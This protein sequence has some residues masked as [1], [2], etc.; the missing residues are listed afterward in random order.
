VGAVLA[1]VDAK[2]HAHLTWAYEPVWAIGTGRTASPEDATEAHAIVRAAIGVAGS[3][4]TAANA[5]ILYGGSVKP[6]NI[7]SLMAASGVD[8]VLVG[9]ASLNPADFNAICRGKVTPA[10]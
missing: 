1:A 9:G 7:D 4:D 6:D 8:G 5:T 10:R 3:G 2:R